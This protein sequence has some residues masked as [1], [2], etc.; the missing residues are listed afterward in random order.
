LAAVSA[1]LALAASSKTGAGILAEA[2][3]DALSSKLATK[4]FFMCFLA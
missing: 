2:K 4:N 3:K 1:A